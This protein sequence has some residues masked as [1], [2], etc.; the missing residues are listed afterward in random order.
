MK[1]R[2]FRAIRAAEMV[3]SAESTTTIHVGVGVFVWLKDN[4]DVP[5][6]TTATLFGFPVAIEG[7]GDD[8]HISVRT[9]QVIP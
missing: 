6:P 2:I 1:S 5:D 4:T 8:D 3:A 7:R 9:V